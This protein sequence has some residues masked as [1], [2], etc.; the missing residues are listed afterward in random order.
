MSLS[1]LSYARA[2]VQGSCSLCSAALIA[3]SSRSSPV[4]S[5]PS[6]KPPSV[7]NSPASIPAPSSSPIIFQQ[8]SPSLI[9]ARTAQGASP[10]HE[11]Q[12]HQ[13]NSSSTTHPSTVQEPIIASLA[14]DPN[15]NLRNLTPQLASHIAVEATDSSPIQHHNR[16]D[17]NQLTP[18][19]P[20]PQEMSKSN[21]MR[22]SRLPST[23][24]GRLL[25][26]GG[27]AAGLGVGAASEAIRRATSPSDGGERPSVFMSDA[28]VRRLVEKLSRMRG[29]ALKLGQFMSIQ[30]SRLLPPQIEEVMMKLQN[31]ANYMPQKQTEQVLAQTLGAD[32]RTHFESF[33]MVPFAAAS[34][35]QVHHAVLSPSSPFAP[36]YPPSMPLAVKIQFPGVR[37]SISSDLSSIKWI[38]MAS[39]LLPKGLFLDNTLKVLGR[40]LDEECDY[41]REAV[42]GAKMRSLIADNKLDSEYRCP[43]VVMELSG[44]MVLTTEFLPGEPLGRAVHYDKIVRDRIGT[45]ILKLCLA[46]LFTFRFMQTDPNWSNF[47][48]DKETG[49]ICLIDFGATRSYSSDFMLKYSALL[50]A[51]IEDDVAKAVKMSQELGYLTGEENQVM[52]R[53]HVE[54]LLALATPFK[55]SSPTPFPFA[56][57]G[58]P[59]SKR[60]RELVP[61]MLNNRLVPPP[62][63]TYS[64]N[65]KLS[66]AFLLCERLGSCVQ[67]QTLFAQ[68]KK[69]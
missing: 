51:A 6:Y 23:R 41:G 3:H 69:S 52:L 55:P 4:P 27:L 13:S 14:T 2:I 40:E 38:L 54:S 5:P 67:T 62:D 30:D 21:Q 49:Q 19:E 64:L 66:G 63:E 59:I 48:Y 39:A 43:Q 7:P 31:S 56:T 26:Y 58:P 47:L 68:M 29:A 17:Q 11:L 53:A 24:L 36:S 20:Q 35:G 15:C 25:H 61:D 22:A 44:P 46:E 16:N 45:K 10:L 65:R 37:D 28:N 32:W 57:L 9:F 12:H 33:D 42:S 60:I 34:I 8:G 1:I 18:A 50:H